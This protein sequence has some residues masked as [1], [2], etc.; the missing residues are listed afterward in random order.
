MSFDISSDIMRDIIYAFL[1]LTYRRNYLFLKYLRRSIILPPD[2]GNITDQSS[3]ESSFRRNLGAVR[4][5]IVRNQL[6][7][8][9]AD[10]GYMYGDSFVV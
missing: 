4:P 9:K 8:K 6:S 10:S 2:I 5:K 3:L 1:R 7:I